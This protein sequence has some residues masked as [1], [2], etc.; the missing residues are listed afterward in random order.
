VTLQ[1][2]LLGTAAAWPQRSQPGRRAGPSAMT[3]RGGQDHYSPEYSSG[4]RI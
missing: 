3:R 4:N 1:M 2:A